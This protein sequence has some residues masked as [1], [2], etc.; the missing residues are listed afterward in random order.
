MILLLKLVTTRRAASI[1]YPD[2]YRFREALILYPARCLKARAVAQM[3]VLDA[4]WP[5]FP[6]ISLPEKRLIDLEGN[7][8]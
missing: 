3:A 7:L 4:D 5:S 2:I 6:R 1:L 8:P